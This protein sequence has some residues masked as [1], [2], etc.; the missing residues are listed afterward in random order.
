MYK[1]F[2]S[3]VCR[4]LIATL[5]SFYST[6]IQKCFMFTQNRTTHSSS[7]NQKLVHVYICHQSWYVCIATSLSSSTANA[8][9]IFNNAYVFVWGDG[10]I[11]RWNN[12][13]VDVLMGM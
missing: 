9:V 4:S 5:L 11:Y 8:A 1:C 2:L 3:G 10:W 13:W 12:E 7:L 6:H